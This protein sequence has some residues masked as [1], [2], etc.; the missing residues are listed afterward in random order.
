[1]FPQTSSPSTEE[2]QALLDAHPHTFHASRS[3]KRLL[4]HWQKL[5]L[6]QLL[7]DQSGT[8]HRRLLQDAQLLCRDGSNG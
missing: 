6:Y 4:E 5:R 3:P 1:M 8:V 7:N 2:L